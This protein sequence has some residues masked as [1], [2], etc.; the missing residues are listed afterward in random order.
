[1]RPSLYFGSLLMVVLLAN[2]CASPDAKRT[3]SDPDAARAHYKHLHSDL[4]DGRVLTLKEAMKL[5]P[6]QGEEF[7]PIY[8]RY[9]QELRALTD[10]RLANLHKFLTHHKGGTLDGQKL[11]ELT[12]EWLQYLQ[13]RLDLWNKYYR[14][15]GDKVSLWAASEFLRVENHIALFYDLTVAS[16]L[17]SP[18]ESPG[19]PQAP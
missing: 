8:K 15:I 17:P 7:R 13:D 9:N 18:G 11:N 1:M 16:D 2:G 12:A 10:S 14:I 5:T 4:Y 6:E 3:I 19:R